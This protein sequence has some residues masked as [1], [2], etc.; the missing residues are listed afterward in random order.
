MDMKR[1]FTVDRPLASM[2]EMIDAPETLAERSDSEVKVTKLGDGD[3]QLEIPIKMG[4]F[5]PKAKCRL[6]FTN[7]QPMR[8][9]EFAID[10]GMMGNSLKGDG[11][12]EMDA[13]GPAKTRVNLIFSGDSSGIAGKLINDQFAKVIER[14][15]QPPKE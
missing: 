12:I 11:T 6:T 4:L 7:K 2:W 15:G 3:Y 5:K 10:A 9:S 14:L 8:S 1:E 13:E